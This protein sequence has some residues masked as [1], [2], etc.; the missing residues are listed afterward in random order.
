MKYL[1]KI[2]YPNEISKGIVSFSSIQIGSVYY[3][4]G[5]NSNFNGVN[6]FNSSILKF[7]LI[8]MNGK[9]WRN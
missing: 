6:Q 7:N 8:I 2:H 9:N 3:I 4:I 5:G 1:T